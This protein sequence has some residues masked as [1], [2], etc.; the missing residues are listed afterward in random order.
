MGKTMA[1][2]VDK[3]LADGVI[4]EDEYLNIQNIQGKIAGVDQPNRKRPV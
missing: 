3:A 1:A 4:T 2:E